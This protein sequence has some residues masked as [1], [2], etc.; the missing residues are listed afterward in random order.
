M[1]ID[2]SLDNEIDFLMFFLP[3]EEVILLGGVEQSCSVWMWIVLKN[4]NCSV[5]SDTGL[6]VCRLQLASIPVGPFQLQI[7]SDSMCR[8]HTS[9]VGQTK[10]VSGK[11]AGSTRR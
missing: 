6:P 9:S 11:P 4:Q 1:Q 2:P 3:A 5:I 7:L 10:K 8:P